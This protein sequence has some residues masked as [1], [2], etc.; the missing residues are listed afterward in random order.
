V[1]PDDASSLESPLPPSET[2]VLTDAEFQKIVIDWNSARADY[3]PD[4]A[5]H[6]LIEDHAARSPGAI[7]A[8][9]DGRE[10][11]YGEMN[12]RADALAR[13]LIALGVKPDTLVPI[14]VP[15]SVE[16]M[17]GI[18]GILK[19]GGAY[20][21]ID[22]NYPADRREFVL[23]D[24]SSP[25]LVTEKGL[26]ETLSRDGLTLVL[27]DDET[28]F[29]AAT[30]PL[31]KV[32]PGNL[33]YAIY[34][35]GS[36]GKPKGVL[37][38]HRNLASSLAA[39]VAYYRESK[40]TN[41]LLLWSYAFDG[42]V[43]GIFWMLATGGRLTMVP[44]G[45]QQDVP[46][47]ANLV[48]RQQ[49]DTIGCL[50]SVYALLLDCW[51]SA[52]PPALKCIIVAGEA[53]PPKLIAQHQRQVPHATVY[54]EYGPT[55]GTVWST[56]YRCD[57]A[58][59]GPNV[60]IGRVIPNAQVYLLGEK[61]QPV[62]IGVTGE[63]C[64]GGDILAQGYLNRPDLTA[65][66]FVPNLFRTGERLYLTGDY[67]RF[68]ADGNIEFLGRRDA[69]IKIR[70]FRVEL[71]EIE[72]V[73]ARAES[74]NECVVVVREDQ[75]GNQQVVAYVT[76][77]PGAIFSVSALRHFVRTHLPEYMVPAA[78][79]R[80][81][82]FPVTAVGKVDRKALPVPDPQASPSWR[83]RSPISGK[84]NSTSR[85]SASRTTSSTSAAIPSRSC[86]SISSF[87]KCSPAKF[88]SPTFFSIRPSAVS[89]N[90]STR[91]SPTPA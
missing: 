7:A 73:L 69:Q 51:Q 47:I 21:P 10:L 24:V 76:L 74:V 49:V 4:R 26:V 71:G 29:A 81:E 86:A 54:N 64:I 72:A 40:L 36:T 8:T 78:V 65:E 90:G 14:C 1:K 63:I 89:W 6:E 62:P 2:P 52:P 61:L 31:P 46:L 39:R 17:V 77:H 3:A 82:R 20:V 38:T 28:A 80:M 9:C 32:Q 23:A 5:V 85:R 27:I 56:V 57:T 19:A 30:P 35:S 41:F 16:M 60:P 59:E 42:S 18:L 67:G 79:V 45:G 15:R 84:R 83:T 68:Q 50:P 22:P 66:R 25:I 55:E 48:T 12:R 91:R 44:E 70:G 37:I 43:A 53:C 87:K 11:T 13:K 88:R 34:T 75:P 33:A 58:I